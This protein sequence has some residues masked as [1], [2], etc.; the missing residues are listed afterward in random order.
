[1]PPNYKEPEDRINLFPTLG[2]FRAESLAN[3][4]KSD[5][6]FDLLIKIWENS[7]EKLW[8]WGYWQ[9]YLRCGEIVLDC[10]TQLKKR[11][12][13]GQV[14]NELGWVQME[15]GNFKIAK[16]RFSESL[17]IFQDT[18]NLLSQGQSL[19]YMGVWY[20][21]QRYFGLALKYYQKALEKT[22]E[23]QCVNLTESEKQRLMHQQF[24]I[25]NLLGNLY[26]KLWN[27]NTSR[28]EF[29]AGLRGFKKPQKLYVSPAP[30]S[31]IY[32]Q[33]VFLL[34]L[35][36]VAMLK[37]Q[38]H[39]A[40][41]YFDRCHQL[42]INIDRSDLEAGV[43]LRMAEL[44]RIQG[45]N[46]KADELA[47]QAEKISETEAPPLRNQAMALRSQLKGDRRQQIK[48]AIYKIKM[49]IALITNLAIHAP[50]VLLQY[51][52]FSL[53]FTSIDKIIAK[54]KKLKVNLKYKLK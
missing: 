42:S 33:P 43:L 26:F 17:Q 40:Q 4:E 19:R 46:A 1:M 25:H 23:S 47:K 3:S 35:G 29:I 45:Q 38:Y 22:L 36:R 27:L 15:Q 37:R 12:I 20:F 7:S 6:S 24:E 32:F 34:N 16:I 31:Y 49:L 30:S 5:Y 50:L 2:K 44:A 9:D 54:I 48:A 21:R 13:Q 52:Y 41:S 28:R 18:A 39:K 51:I 8:A 14:L 11:D 53:F 10:A